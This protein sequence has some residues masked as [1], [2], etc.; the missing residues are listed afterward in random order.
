LGGKTFKFFLVVAKKNI[1]EYP[2][3]ED[4]ILLT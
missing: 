2:A 1:L 3:G 4:S